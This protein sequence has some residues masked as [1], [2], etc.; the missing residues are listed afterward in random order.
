MNDAGRQGNPQPFQI[1]HPDEPDA[2]LKAGLQLLRMGW[3][4]IPINGSTK[5]PRGVGWQYAEDRLGFL[6][7]HFQPGD[8]LGVVAGQPAGFS[9]EHGPLFTGSLD[10]DFVDKAASDALRAVLAKLATRDGRTPKFL[11]HVR[12]SALDSFSQ[13]VKWTRGDETIS[14]QVLGRSRHKDRGPKQ[15]VVWGMHKAAKKPYDWNADANGYTIFDYGPDGGPIV[16]LQALL[17][18]ADAVLAPQGWVR[19]VKSPTQEQGDPDD[20]LGALT[21]EERGHM[22]GWARNLI[23]GV[24]IKL[25]QMGEKTGRGSVV[26]DL[27]I[28]VAPVL[29]AGALA[30]EEVEE[31]IGA[32]CDWSAVERDFA[33]GLNAAVDLERNWA[34]H[35]LKRFRDLAGL[36][37][38]SRAQAEAR[39]TAGS[40]GGAASGKA[41]GFPIWA[42]LTAAII[43]YLIDVVK[44]RKSEEAKTQLILDGVAFAASLI[45]AGGTTAET[46]VSMWALPSEKLSDKQKPRALKIKELFAVLSPDNDPAMALYAADKHVGGKTAGEAVRLALFKFKGAAA[47]ETAVVEGVE[48]NLIDVEELNKR[49]ARFCAPGL[50]PAWVDRNGGQ[51]LDVKALAILTTGEF[52]TYPDMETGNTAFKP[53][54]EAWRAWNGVHTYRD[55]VFTNKAVGDEVLNLFHGFGVEPA[56]GDCGLILQH[57]KE[58]LCAGDALVYER[59]L[60]LEAWKLQHVGEPSRV[61]LTVVT[62]EHQTGKGIYFEQVMGKIWGRA[63]ANETNTE[64]L[65]GRFNDVLRGK[66]YLLLDETA[67]Q[68]D[69]RVADAL[70]RASTAKRMN[71]EPKGGA[72][73]ECPVGLNVTLLSNHEH[74]AH[75]EEGDARYWIMKPS[76]HR[77]G[78]HDYFAA[79]GCQ[80]ENGGPAALLDFLLKR[81]VSAFNPQRDVP[82]D[83]DAKRDMAAMSAKRGTPRAWL[84]DVVMR[85]SFSAAAGVGMA[86]N[87]AGRPEAFKAKPDEA[88]AMR[89]DFGCYATTDMLFKAYEDWYKLQKG[90]WIAD[91]TS[92]AGFKM[93]AFGFEHAER[94]R[95]RAGGQRRGWH[96]PDRRELAM[97]LGVR[98]EEPDDD[99]EE[100]DRQAA[101]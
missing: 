81:D 83:N 1:P 25:A 14:M 72:K 91:P 94:K 80:V 11:V 26:F 27:M 10:V 37:E 12:L 55:I 58:V 57:V 34:L 70:K 66:S 100:E 84:I 93:A 46:L 21:D 19:K 3:A 65:S 95:G 61:I 62:P 43:D 69:N 5:L 88:G 38:E 52:I 71:L 44:S 101:E 35:E 76:Q 48:V 6:Q 64:A 36:R 56:Q 50:P 51:I 47:H 79:L 67:F 30:V 4:V 98:F 87:D 63:F 85:G 45:G 82:M 60:D 42:A 74:A 15:N 9:L 17:T 75:V 31:L 32:A 16:G 2:A 41:Y 59:F 8:S 54:Q 73:F 20:A 89:L 39:A 92:I 28:K 40:E 29:G 22:A 90:R 78:D 7:A 33:N 97:L 53:A 18:A 24:C 23:N 86:A 68:G 96:I 49:F 99:D 13:D 77:K